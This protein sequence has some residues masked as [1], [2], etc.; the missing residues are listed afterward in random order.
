MSQR[1][2]SRKSKPNSWRHN[3]TPAII[4]K[5]LLELFSHS[6]YVDPI[7]IYR[8]YV[9]NA[10]DAIDEA[11]NVGLLVSTNPG[12][13]EISI[14]INNRTVRIR[15]NGAGVK[16]DKF[17]EVLTSFGASLKRGTQARGF[18]G[19]GRLAG[20][21]YCQELI[22]RSRSLGESDI[23]EM[24]WDC[25]NIKA[26]L[27]SINSN[28]S[29]IDL[30]DGVVSVRRVDG[31]DWPEHFFEVEL[32][33][34]V[35]LK[36]DSLLNNL[37]V[38]DYL[39]EIAPVP[40]SPEFAFGSEI[41]SALSNHI[42][43]GNLDI[44]IEGI[45]D[46]VYRPHRNDFQVRGGVHDEFTDVE[47]RLIPASDEQDGAIAWFLHHGYNG[48][49]PNPQIRGLRL[50]TGNIQVG[51]RDVLEEL[52]PEQRFNSWA[53]G[54]I[55]TIDKRIIPNGRRDNYE[56]NVHFTHLTNHISPIARQIS[57]R[58]RQSSI[59]R[60]LVHTFRRHEALVNNKLQAIT[61]GGLD[62]TSRQKQVNEID[63]LVTR[64]RGILSRS[65]L[66]A[67]MQKSL[68]RSV[69]KLEKKSEEARTYEGI[70]EPLTQLS[71]NKR[72]AY[73]KIIALIYECS[74]NHSNAHSLVESILKKLG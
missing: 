5:D 54:E 48:A 1:L 55:H 59:L 40:F 35:R 45:S 29:L 71:A 31:Q 13:V 34:A 19:I 14:D 42:P 50:R 20:L 25:R 10:A 70:A 49:I 4:G 58:C 38:Y 21:G 8:E 60:N 51:G 73:Q 17:E 11:H 41:T 22:F 57:A 6:M 36:N 3:T 64:M 15:D 24:C 2:A 63:E 65:I 28:R 56:Q 74:S 26:E 68:K 46:P 62:P 16:Q 37:A 23:S 69:D 47:V 66:P 12:K 52:F 43:L 18:R 44:R 32:R 27:H 7:T 39:S 67:D 72:K 61:Q 53:V 33:G 9:Q 30:V